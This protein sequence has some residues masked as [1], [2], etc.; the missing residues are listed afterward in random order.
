MGDMKVDT[1]APSSRSS[2]DQP[3]S[4]ADAEKVRALVLFQWWL[5]NPSAC[6]GM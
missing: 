2:S 5:A 4:D 6:R 1:A 3:A